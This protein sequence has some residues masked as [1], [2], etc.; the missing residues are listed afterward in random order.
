MSDLYIVLSILFLSTVVQSTCSFG[1]AL[2]A[3]PLLA[4]VIDI[5]TATPLITLLSCSIAIAIVS[6]NRREIQI[7]NAW[8]LIISAC[9]GI[10]LGIMFL[11]HVD[12]NVL[13]IVLALTVIV[14][15]MLNLLTFKAIR[16]LHVN[17]A[18]IFGFISG[19]FGGAYNTGG[20]P[21]VLYGSLMNWNPAVFRATIQSYSLCTNVF[22]IIGH[23]L[24]GNVTRA[25]LF[26]YVCALPVAGLAIWLGN[27]IHKTIPAEKYTIYVKLLLLVLG[28]RLF[29]TCFA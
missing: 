9:L 23:T 21:V 13:K 18:F 26:Y 24:A 16:L 14:F 6:E 5:K 4:S 29:Y 2:I 15:T 10:P 3:L 8:R 22:A 12:G 25:V 20:P 11:S 7:R 19:I 1:A 28:I 17:Y 27:I